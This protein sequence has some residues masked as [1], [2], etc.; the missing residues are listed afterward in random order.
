MFFLG[1]GGG[2]VGAIQTSMVPKAEKNSGRDQF[3][4]CV[5]SLRNNFADRV[6]ITVVSSK[7]IDPVPNRCIVNKY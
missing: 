3:L 4:R 6:C 5:V 7:K 1:G 2:L